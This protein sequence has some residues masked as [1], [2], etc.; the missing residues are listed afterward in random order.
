[1]PAGDETIIKVG[2][3]QIHILCGAF[4]CAQI[5]NKSPLLLD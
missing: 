1:V 5:I 2:G 3:M 4:V